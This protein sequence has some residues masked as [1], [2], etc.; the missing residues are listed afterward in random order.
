MNSAKVLGAPKLG[1]SGSRVWYRYRVSL[2]GTSG[3][4]PAH[5]V[6]PDAATLHWNADRKS[7]SVDSIFR[8][9]D[10]DCDVE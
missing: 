7:W 10:R 9:Y 3:G 1:R 2:R 4:K 6:I 8:C 5:C